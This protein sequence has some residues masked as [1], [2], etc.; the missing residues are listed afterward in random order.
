MRGE[1]MLVLF[2]DVYPAPKT[3]PNT[4]QVLNK[5]LLDDQICKIGIVVSASQ[6]GFRDSITCRNK[7]FL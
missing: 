3:V 5:C 4:Y 6:G 7:Y 1:A 2:E